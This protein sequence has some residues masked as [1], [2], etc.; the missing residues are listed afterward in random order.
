MREIDRPDAPGPPP[1]LD[2][3]DGAVPVARRFNDPYF[4]LSG[5]LAETRHVFLAGNGL[6]ARLAPGFRISELGFGTGLNM[7]A[8]LLAWRAAGV[9]GPLRYTA[10]EAYPLA[11][12]DMARAL[13]AF[14]E[15][16]A[17]AVPVLPQWAAGS[18]RIDLPDLEAEIVTGDARDTLPVWDGRAD[19]WFLDGFS[20]ARNPE[21][22]EPDLLA[23]VAAH[24]RTGATF[25]TYTAAGAVRR[26]LQ[27]A[28]FRVER[29]AGYGTKRHMTRGW[30]A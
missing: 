27:A 4:S 13:S 18:R 20:P 24:C 9:A 6:P 26:A 30:L 11:A 8:A 23:A 25:A 28:G 7:I 21:M 22:W 19:A 17:A 2:W 5:G 15:A 10:F 16:A 3:R 12:D 29:C 14:P 1:A